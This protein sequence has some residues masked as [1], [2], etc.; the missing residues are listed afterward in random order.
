MPVQQ[1][2]NNGD[3]AIACD[4][5][6]VAEKSAAWIEEFE[7]GVSKARSMLCLIL[8]VWEWEKAVKYGQILV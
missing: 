2:G 7:G 5:T 4:D 8:C 6:P 3:R 1:K